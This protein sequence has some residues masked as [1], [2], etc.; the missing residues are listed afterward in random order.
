MPSSVPGRSMPR[1]STVSLVS[2][3]S[4]STPMMTMMPI[5]TLIKKAQCQLALVTSQPPT[6]GPIAAMPPMVAPQT[7]NAIARSLPR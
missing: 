6:S 3:T 1:L 2:G 5:G 4:S 7:A